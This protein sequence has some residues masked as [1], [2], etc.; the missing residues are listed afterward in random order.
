MMKSLSH[1]D[2]NH[3][4][5]G[6]SATNNGVASLTGVSFRLALWVEISKVGMP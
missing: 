6:D 5:Q 1:V 3:K 2:L 4:V